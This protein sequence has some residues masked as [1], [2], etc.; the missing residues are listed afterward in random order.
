MLFLL[1]HLRVER[2]ES[3]R[4]HIGAELVVQWLQ[5]Y[6]NENGDKLPDQEKILLPSSMTRYMVYERYREEYSTS[7]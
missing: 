5:L 6:A 3:G 7:V 1:G 4:F 2:M